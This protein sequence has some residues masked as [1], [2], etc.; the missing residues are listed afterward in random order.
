MGLID[1]D[2]DGIYEISVM[3]TDF[4][5][6][7]DKM[8]MS[9]IPLP[10]IIFKYNSLRRRYVP[11][12][13]LFQDYALEGMTTSTNIGTEDQLQHRSIVLRTTLTL[14]YA[15]KRRDGWRYFNQ[16]YKLEDKEEI[17]RRA[18]AI[19]VRQPVYKFIYNRGKHK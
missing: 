16:S 13:S 8:S 12:N 1:L 19:L 11:A 10:M 3:I 9:Q 7:Q 14:I 5:D 2:G 15:G 6:L 4:Y 17:R 18:K